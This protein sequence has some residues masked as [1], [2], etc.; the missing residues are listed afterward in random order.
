M[1]DYYTQMLSVFSKIDSPDEMKKIFEEIFTE[2]ELHDLKL[3][4]ALL[5]M[6]S[7]GH[8]QREISSELGISLCKITRGAKLLKEKKSKVY[9]IFRGGYGDE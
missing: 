5:S 8:S 4:W 7:Q 3:R 6:L 1:N 9:E 2:S